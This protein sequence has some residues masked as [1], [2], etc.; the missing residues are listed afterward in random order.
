MANKKV[1]MPDH[2]NTSH[3]SNLPL[4]LLHQQWAQAWD[5]APPPGM[6]RAMLIRSLEYRLHELE[7]GGPR[8]I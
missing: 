2:K 8:V 3:L 1:N 4:E 7:T 5:R 6:G